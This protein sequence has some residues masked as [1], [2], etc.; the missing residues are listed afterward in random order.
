[1]GASFRVLLAVAAIAVSARGQAVT[2]LNGA[3][4]Q[5]F[6][7]PAH[8]RVFLFVRTDCPISNRY[9]PELQRIANEF[10]GRGVDFWLVYSDHAETAA[11]VERQ[12]ADYKLPGQPLLD[13]HQELARRAQAA[14]SP[15]AA[16]FD[17]AG[18]LAYSGRIDDRYVDFGK[19]RSEAAS[20]DLEEAI[21]DTLADKPVAHPRTRAIGCY[22]AD[23]K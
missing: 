8:V 15:Q 3:A 22:L 14:V 12:I 23:V 20:H 16:V 5:P 17:H 13:A 7:S 9:A 11:N 21:T 2:G 6:Q 4:A 10:K 18:R 1:M 19:S